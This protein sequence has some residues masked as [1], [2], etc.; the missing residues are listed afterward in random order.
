MNK[1]FSTLVASLLLAGALGSP[2]WATTA[3]VPTGFTGN[4]LTAVADVTLGQKYYLV[5]TVGAVKNALSFDG[6]AISWVPI[7]EITAANLCTIEDATGNK[8]YLKWGSQYLVVAA[9]GT[10]SAT[11]SSGSATKFEIKTGT[12]GSTPTIAVDATSGDFTYIAADASA[13]AKVESGNISST[14]GTA[15]AAVQVDNVVTDLNLSSLTDYKVLDDATLSSNLDPA[16]IVWRRLFT[17]ATNAIKIDSDQLSDAAYEDADSKIVLTPSGDKYKLTVGGH[18][19]YVDGITVKVD[20]QDGN[21][22]LFELVDLTEASDNDNRYL[23]FSANGKRYILTSTSNV[24]GASVYDPAMGFTPNALAFKAAEIAAPAAFD[25]PSGYESVALADVTEGKYYLATSATNFVNVGFT[26]SAT[27][28][29]EWTLTKSGTGYTLSS[30]SGDLSVSGNSIVVNK[31]SG[32]KTV[33]NVVEGENGNLYLTTLNNR[34]VQATGTYGVAAEATGT[35]DRPLNPLAIKLCKVKAVSPSFAGAQPNAVVTDFA[36]E[37]VGKYNYITY[38]ADFLKDNTGVAATDAKTVAMWKVTKVSE[39]AYKI[40][41]EKGNKVAFAVDANGVATF[42]SKDGKYATFNYVD[43]K[44]SFTTTGGTYYVSS[45]GTNWIATKDVAPQYNVVFY[46]STLDK[47]NNEGIDFLNGQLGNGFEVIFKEMKDGKLVNLSVEA[48]PLT[49][50][51]M[52]AVAGP[53]AV[54]GTTHEKYPTDLSGSMFLKVAGDYPLTKAGATVAEQLAAFRASTFIAVSATRY[55]DKITDETSN[56]FFEYTTV[57]GAALI[58]QWGSVV[59]ASAIG[60]SGYTEDDY[61][62]GHKL[63]GVNTPVA[64]AA[65]QVSNYANDSYGDP[66]YLSNPTVYAPKDG[67]KNPTFADYETIAGGLKVSVKTYL[68]KN[69]VGAYDGDAYDMV[70]FGTTNQVKQKDIVGLVNIVSRNYKTYDKVYA[71]GD[72]GDIVKLAAERV[73]LH[74]PE[75]QFYVTATD[76]DLF[77]FTN[78][79]SGRKVFE[80]SVTLKKVPGKDNVYAVGNAAKDTILV[81][82]A[83]VGDKF[84][85][86]ANYD[87]QSQ[88]ENKAYYIMPKS[89]VVNGREIYLAEN[90]EGNHAIGASADEADAINWRFVKYTAPGVAEKLYND[91][92][93]T[94]NEDAISYLKDGNYKTKND[95][96]VKFVYALYNES[97]GEYLNYDKTANGKA[98]YCDPEMV[99]GTTTADAV[100]DNASKFILKEKNDGTYNLIVVDENGRFDHQT[101]SETYGK[102]SMS[103]EKAYIGVNDAKL[104]KES[105]I[106]KIS[107]NDLFLIKE[108][109]APKYRSVATF[110]TI[111]IY[112]NDNEKIALYER[113]NFLGMQH[114]ADVPDMAAAMFVDTAYVSNTNKPQYLLVVEPELIWHDANCHIP[115]HP[116]VDPTAV[117]TVKGRFLVNMVDSLNAWGNLHNNPYEWETYPKLA[118]KNGYHAANKLV[119][120]TA[121]PSAANVIDLS[122]NIDK[123]GT[124]AFRYVDRSQGSFV[125]ETGTKD[126]KGNAG[127]GYIK[128]LNGTPVVVPSIALAE[129]FNLDAD[130]HSNPTANE[131]VTTSEVSVIAG[132]GDVTINGAAGKKVTI[133]NVLGQTIANTVLSSDNATI[134]APAGIVVVAV[135]GE[136]AVKAIVK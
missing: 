90:H 136:A 9:D 56:N 35:G 102:F 92:I 95:T 70:Y 22:S 40:A 135:E 63:Y 21:S 104:N 101:G 2:I 97:N 122:K 77:T 84:D 15:F 130:E 132:N 88:L 30:A 62:E 52:T 19:V 18:N 126:S 112:K 59:N 44:L 23:A 79:E 49:K 31:T 64:N 5:A 20:P 91:S 10:V 134:A 37:A 55:S 103:D 38:G 47:D 74:N 57:K 124:F 46:V 48:N 116:A 100:R 111:R 131:G 114:L 60:E 119:I 127:T 66:V 4:D 73:V 13:F 58:S 43:G 75:G 72:N 34:V 80:N 1:K 68:K 109:D 42:N 45:N 17:S 50:G 113:G 85:G 25:V 115:G 107:D 6:S 129:V 61:K 99:A 110:D 83:T 96:I 118:F 98:Y 16:S 8:F 14:A 7:T 27:D 87:V 123:I 41:D 36:K 94:I 108:V 67:V 39:G 86:Y 24:I 26:G 71:N 29:V 65:F 81:A 106:Y 33:L 76:D 89:G 11:E 3:L 54:D 121:K 93:I 78:R 12:G 105:S 28:A 120:E 32:S 117:D 53:K 51:E 133:S 128:W 69:Y 82:E 125:I